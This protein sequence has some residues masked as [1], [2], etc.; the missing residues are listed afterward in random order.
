MKEIGFGEVI[1]RVRL[2]GHGGGGHAG[3]GGHSGGGGGGVMSHHNN[4]KNYPHGRRVNSSTT[5]NIGFIH[6]AFLVF[7]FLF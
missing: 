1:R 3:G 7:F 6:L 2:Q 4:D 5:N